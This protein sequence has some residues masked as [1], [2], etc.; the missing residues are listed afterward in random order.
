MRWPRPAALAGLLLAVTLAGC[1]SSYD[2]LLDKSRILGVSVSPSPVPAPGASGSS[3]VTIAVDVDANSGK[4][5]LI[6]RWRDPARN[7]EWQYF[8]VF[9]ICE[10][11]GSDSC[12]LRTVSITCTS[13]AFGIATDR[14]VRC[15][16]AGLRV[17]TGTYRW[18]VAIDR[19]SN[20]SLSCDGPEDEREFDVTFR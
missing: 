10:R 15:D 16:P 3:A 5:Y 1:P 18:R 17:Y 8:G 12:G 7:G 2:E 4:D 19:C 20:L 6:F 11:N 9:G 13:S 14:D